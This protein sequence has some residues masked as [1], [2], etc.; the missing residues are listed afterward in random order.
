MTDSETTTHTVT[1]QEHIVAV[2]EPSRDGEATL[3]IAQEAVGRGAR[4]TV[5]VLVTRKVMSDIRDFAYSENLT[6]PDASEIYFERL[7][8]TYS[9]RVGGSHT[10]AIVTKSASSGRTVFETAV[11]ARPTTIAMP[12][13]LAGRRGWRS[14]VAHSRVRVVIAPSTAA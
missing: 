10:S 7:S 4:A 6:V 1:A 2:V 13:R 8:E 12:Q 5:V 14:S 9:S 11:R 3:A